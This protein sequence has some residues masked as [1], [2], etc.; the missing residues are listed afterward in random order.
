[1]TVP[2]ALLLWFAGAL[3][4]FDA[5]ADVGTNPKSGSARYD[6]AT[7]EYEVTGGGANIWGTED[8]F[9]FVHRKVEGDFTFEADVRLVGAGVNPHRKAALM[10]RQTLEADSPYAD[11]AVH[12]DGLT[13]LQFRRDKGGQTAEV[14]SVMR[15]PRRLRLERRGDVITMSV[16]EAGETLIE[17]E[18]ITLRLSGPVYLGLAVCSHDANVLET[19][20]FTNVSVR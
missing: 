14:K 12:G 2:L 4:V 18:P 1:M 13:S 16:G 17:A 3:G 8:A 19:A 6:A 9:H 7:K 5:S 10:V 15:A 11:A 20:V